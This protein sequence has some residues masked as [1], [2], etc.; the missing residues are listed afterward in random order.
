MISGTCSIIVL[1]IL[2]VLL[3][4]KESMVIA[5]ISTRTCFI[6]VCCMILKRKEANTENPGM[7]ARK[8]IPCQPEP[9]ITMKPAVHQQPQPSVIPNNMGLPAIAYSSDLAPLCWSAQQF[10]MAGP[11][12]PRPM[13]SGLLTTTCTLTFL[14]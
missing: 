1:L 9:P 14:Q 8:L 5:E 10:P 7:E 12:A 6:K 11:L 13:E 3:V 4:A 2:I